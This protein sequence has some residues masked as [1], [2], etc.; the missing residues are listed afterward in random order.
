MSNTAYN[1]FVI[2][3]GFC[4]LGL[5][6]ILISYSTA[7]PG[8]DQF[9][10]SIIL[11]TIDGDTSS[12]LYLSE[13]AKITGDSEDYWDS[14]GAT[15]YLYEINNLTQLLLNEELFMQNVSM[16]DYGGFSKK[17]HL[18]IVEMNITNIP[19]KEEIQNKYAELFRRYENG[20]FLF[21][22]FTPTVY[23]AHHFSETSYPDVN[24]TI[25]SVYSTFVG[26]LEYLITVQFYAEIEINNTP[27]QTSFT[28]ILLLDDVGKVYFFLTDETGWTTVD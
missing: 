19:T 3:L 5:P 18:F 21:Y 16:K 20:T 14:L 7:P 9:N 8:I 2:L 27:L 15:E 23:L 22:A 24:N 6:I 25:H 12:A 13:T 4:L 1:M 26:N 17:V 11:N 28:R 10:S